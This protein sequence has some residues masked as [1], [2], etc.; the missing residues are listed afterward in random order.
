L[1]RTLEG[2]VETEGLEGRKREGEELDEERGE[3]RGGKEVSLVSFR[4]LLNSETPRI[5]RA[6]V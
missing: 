2:R 1:S 6:I 5:D 4:D 3:T